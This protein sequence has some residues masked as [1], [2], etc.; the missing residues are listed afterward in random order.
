MAEEKVQQDEDVKWDQPSAPSQEKGILDRAK[1]VG[2]AAGFG[3]V[4]GFFTPQIA[5]G[6][7]QI[8]EKIP[9][10]PAQMAGKAMQAAVPS[11]TGL[12]Q[13]S[14]GAATG[15]FSGAIVTGKQI[16]RAHV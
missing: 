8:M 16:G 1:D 14:I 7:G 2:V 3:G 6:T 5:M 13:Q 12:K 10:K 11:L 15:A 4:A 9:Y